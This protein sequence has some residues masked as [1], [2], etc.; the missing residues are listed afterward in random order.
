[1]LG[2]DFRVESLSILSVGL[3]ELRL[4]GNRSLVTEEHCWRGVN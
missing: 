4:E 2:L 1:M 3:A